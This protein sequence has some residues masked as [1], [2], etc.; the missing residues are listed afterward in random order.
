MDRLFELLEI[1]ASGSSKKPRNFFKMFF[2]V[3]LPHL[4]TYIFLIFS[5]NEPDL[6]AGIDPGMAFN[7]FQSS[8]LDKTRR[9]SNPQPLDHELSPLTTRPDLRP[10]KKTQKL[11]QPN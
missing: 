7:P 10:Y 11:T 1:V 5:M 8:I 4:A 2:F 6:G 9:D 3:G